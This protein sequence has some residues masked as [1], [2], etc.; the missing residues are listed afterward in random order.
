MTKSNGIG[1][2]LKKIIR[3]PFILSLKVR[4]MRIKFASSMPIST[5]IENYDR[6]QIGNH[7]N[8][9]ERTIIRV[10]DKKSRI[11]I[12]N[13]FCGGND[14]KILFCGSV[15]LGDDITCAGNVFITSENHGLDPRTRSFNDNVLESSDVIIEDGVWLGEKTI[16]LP[17]V[18]IG[19]KT[20]IGAGSVVTKN[21]PSYSI[22]VGNP[23]Q[24]IKK[25]D[26]KEKKYK[27]TK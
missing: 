20:I 10:F 6:I 2:K 9:D 18:K 14:L 21:I 26:F 15:K 17:G 4:G 3:M 12:G 11:I 8:F 24:V 23:A 13:N 1:R 25:W 27:S 5:V 7:C 16:I 19:K 22:A